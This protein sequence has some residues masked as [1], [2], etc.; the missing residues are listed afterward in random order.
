MSGRRIDVN[1]RSLRS[2]PPVPRRVQITRCLGE[3]R[4]KA[5][6]APQD[7][8]LHGSAFFTFGMVYGSKS[9]PGPPPGMSP[10]WTRPLLPFSN[11]L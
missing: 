3:G 7:C 9:Y 1:G 8:P 4:L 11:I 10:M 2:Q 5:P 6:S